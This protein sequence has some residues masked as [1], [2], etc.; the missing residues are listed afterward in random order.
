MLPFPKI[1]AC[2]LLAEVAAR[3]HNELYAAKYDADV[4]CKAGNALSTKG[5]GRVQPVEWKDCHEALG[6][7]E[8]KGVVMP[9]GPGQDLSPPGV[10]LQYNEYIVYDTAQ[11]RLRYLLK[12]KMR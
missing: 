8:L 5:V 2:L 6:N 11:I 3:P 7:E 10:F 9:S 1:S 4:L 12:V